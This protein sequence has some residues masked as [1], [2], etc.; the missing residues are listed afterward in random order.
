MVQGFGFRASDLWV[1]GL[2]LWVDCQVLGF[3]FIARFWASFHCQ[4][5]GFGFMVPTWQI[6]TPLGLIESAPKK[7]R[8]V[9]P[10]ELV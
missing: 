6:T 5:L 1:S 8:T 10:P 7:L 2:G 9:C 4:V 3:A